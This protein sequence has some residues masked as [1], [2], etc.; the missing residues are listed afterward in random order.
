[1]VNFYVH[2]VI[3]RIRGLLFIGH[4]LV[5]DRTVCGI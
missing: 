4:E 2:C 3:S 5:I 1:M